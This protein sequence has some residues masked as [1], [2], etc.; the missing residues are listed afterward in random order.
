[1]GV[2]SL[3]VDYTQASTEKME[4]QMEWLAP[5]QSKT[6]FNLGKISANQKGLSSAARVIS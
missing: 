4:R 2:T 6:F 5:T 3:V 1:V